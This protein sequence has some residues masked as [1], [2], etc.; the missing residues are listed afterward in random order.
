MLQSNVIKKA[1]RASVRDGRLRFTVFTTRGLKITLK[2]V[3]FERRYVTNGQSLCLF[4]A[5]ERIWP[6]KPTCISDSE[7][8]RFCR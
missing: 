4:E 5:N 8:M 7:L 2:D 6:E 3:P 1:V